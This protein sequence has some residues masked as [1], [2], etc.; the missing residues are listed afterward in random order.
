MKAIIWTKYGPPDVLQLREV[1]KPAPKDDEVLIKIHATTVFAGDAELR[2][3]KLPFIMA[4]PLRL[5]IGFIRPKRIKILG[6]EL[7]GKIEAVGKDVKL[8]KKGDQIFSQSGFIGGGIC[9][10][11]VS[12]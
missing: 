6:Q 9:R 3:L 7:A 10:V 4:L 2:S 5:Y 12:A 1:E 11:R 8:F